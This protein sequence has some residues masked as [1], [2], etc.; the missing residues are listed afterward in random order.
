MIVV[1]LLRDTCRFQARL[2]APGRIVGGAVAVMLVALAML[3]CAGQ[4]F[5]AP[6]W[7]VRPIFTPGHIAPGASGE[8]IVSA[9]N[10]GDGAFTVSGATPVK[11]SAQLPQGVT[12]TSIEDWGETAFNGRSKKLAWV[13]DLAALSCESTGKTSG[14]SGFIY[15]YETSEMVLWVTVAANAQPGLKAK[16]FASGGGAGP[17]SSEDVIP[18]GSEPVKFGVER[19]EQVPYNEDG[20]IDTQAGSHPFQLTTTLAFNEAFEKENEHTSPKPAPLAMPKELAFDL[21]PGLVGNPTAIPQCPIN[22][23]QPSS[24]SNSTECSP[25]TAVGVISITLSFHELEF[26]NYFAQP[27]ELVEPVYNLTPSPGEPARFGFLVETGLGPN[28]PVFLDTSVRTGGNYG[29]VVEVHNIPE[30]LWFLG[31]QLSF[32]GV[33]GNPLHNIARGLCMFG[34]GGQACTPEG[35]PLVESPVLTLPTS[36]TGLSDPLTATMEAA[37]WEHPGERLG[38]EYVL[39]ETSGN[40]LGLDGCNRLEFNPSVSVTPDSQDGSSA[41]GLTVGIHLPQEAILS[42]KGLAEANVQN[43]TVTLPAGVAV[44]PS[45][46]D[47]LQACSEAQ[48]G[49]S[50][51]GAASCPEASKV[52]TVEI[53]SPLVTEPVVGAVYLA[54][55]NANPFGS[56]L[57]LYIVAEDHAAG[58]LIKVAGEVKLNAV[59]GQ[60]VSTFDNTPQLPFEDLKLHFF[61]GARAPLTS[62]AQCGNYITTASI[63]PW[64]ANPAAEAS[65]EFQI[66]TGP[67]GT[68]CANPL[69]FDPSLTAGSTNIQ[70]GAFSP[71]T[72]TMSRED[73]QQNLDA[74]Q[75]HM[76]P[77]LL[78]TLSSVK[79][80][81]EPQADM[82][83][84]GP[85]SLIGETIVSVGLG[86]EPFS[87]TGGK[88][89]ITGPY[90]GAPYGLSIVNPAK[91]GPF[92][93]G[94][95]IVRA[96]IAVDPITA[97]LTITTDASGPYAIPQ[98]L[99]G[100]PLQIKHVNVTINRPG[101]TF[102]PTNCD[103]AAITGTL[104]SSQGA[105]SA[106]SVPFQVTN[107]ATLAFK[108]IFDV[109]TA[110]KTSRA[111]GA[112]LHV[113]LAYPKATAGTQANIRSVKVD[114]P[115]Q[116]P[117]ELK[118]LQ[119]ACPDFTFEE[120]PA[121]C[122]PESRIGTAH[123]TTPILPVA[124]T[125]PVYFVSH[126]GLKFPELVIVLS[127]YGT[128]VQL[129]AETFISKT[130]I[131]SS[132]F[133]TIPDVPVNTFE[134]TLP[135]GKYSALA[136]PTNKLC[137]EALLMPTA[138][139]A[140]NGLTIHQNTPITTTGCTKT[141]N[142][143]KA[144]TKQETKHKRKA[145]KK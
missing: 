97:A 85:E 37:S 56:L 73:G 46:S 107:C 136:A 94:T 72:M 90:E 104:T 98:I 27:V 32:W 81:E 115:K 12:V 9:T 45:A 75:L 26:G 78:G 139:T 93:L 143:K 131:T 125:G 140:Q 53:T 133:R 10:L 106:L 16:L 99:D 23:F 8:M 51:A 114:L 121:N 116:L 24:L 1:R 38:S 2:T 44:N 14:S 67:N 36:C 118:T 105:S 128:T 6:M 15:P 144:D 100:I 47:G 49:L 18:I 13:C 39:H 145:K 62:P 135:Q 57:A 3:A 86:S 108:P 58:I 119:K 25:G 66:T 40:Q 50:S 41:T 137:K 129:H 95:V 124:L 80:C 126:A 101:F 109:S 132:T 61:G 54:E 141:K 48:V 84:C 88:V 4:A 96:K 77:G 83:T 87:V 31:A 30:T 69:P 19:F 120:D 21:P 65:S 33:P 20:S 92:N 123:A 43:T 89:Y 68:P 64:S 117:S 60:L 79:L 110:G 70:S 138:F 111:K 7:S 34:V 71:F 55:Q 76:P 28:V 17:G 91:A 59:T 74:V 127:G 130:G 102:N 112:S 5:A 122:S 22:K 134:L 52:G 82:G 11:I 63:E 113:K 42:P 142:T 29:V 35:E 103:P